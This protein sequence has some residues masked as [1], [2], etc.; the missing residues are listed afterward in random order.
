[1]EPVSYTHLFFTVFLIVGFVPF[2]V[3]VISPSTIAHSFVSAL[4]GQARFYQFTET[5][6]NDFMG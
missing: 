6:H 1:M 2:A 4:K 5:F 3:I